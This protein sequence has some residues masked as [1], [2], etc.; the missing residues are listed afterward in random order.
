MVLGPYNAGFVLLQAA[1]FFSHR[2]ACA[3]CR[4]HAAGA[5]GD[6]KIF[7]PIYSHFLLRKVQDCQ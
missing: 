6:P 5:G 1:G 3:Y 2:A 4:F 7:K